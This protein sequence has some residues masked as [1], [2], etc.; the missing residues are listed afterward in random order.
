MSQDFNEA[1]LLSIKEFAEY[2]GVKQHVLRHYD[3]LGLFCPAVR[4]ENGYRYYSPQ[5][6]TTL[7]MVCVLSDMKALLREIGE[8]T[9]KR[10]PETIMDL[11]EKQEL[12]IDAEVRRLHDSHSIIHMYRTLIHTGLSANENEI[13]VMEMDEF[14]IFLGEKNSFKDN[15][16]FYAD[17]INFCKYTRERG[18]NLSYPIGGYF[19]DMKTFIGAS[20]KPTYFFS[21]SPTGYD[22]KPAGKY[23]V[24]YSRGYYGR[25]G[26]L[27][28]RLVEYANEHSLEFTGPVYA[29]YV[30]DEVSVKEPDNYLAQVSVQ[31]KKKRR[32]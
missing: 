17:F 11:L 24:G 13:S 7:N 28:S 5:Q 30:E 22:I 14:P 25:M 32:G 27:P 29:I 20:G 31:F 4:G 2:T 6:I 12:K 26:D 9:K 3:E 1:E 15:A 23:L 8:L 10:S 16:G 21:T 18:I 19:K